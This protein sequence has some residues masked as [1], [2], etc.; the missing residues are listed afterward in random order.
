MLIYYN[1]L[2][3]NIT[4]IFFKILKRIISFW[5]N[6][7]PIVW[8]KLVVTCNAKKT[9]R[10]MLERGEGKGKIAENNKYKYDVK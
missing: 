4:R 3:F 5:F 9:D 8:R 2:F 6:F 10:R 1:Y 7:V